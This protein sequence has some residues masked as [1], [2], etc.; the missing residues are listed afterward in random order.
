MMS[1]LPPESGEGGVLFDQLVG[2]HK[3]RQWHGE[4]ERGFDATRLGIID[5]GDVN[6][7]ARV[8]KLRDARL[9][10]GAVLAYFSKDREL[11]RGEEIQEGEAWCPGPQEEGDE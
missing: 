10:C 3:K 1:T 5:D 8:A 6:R 4:A 9:R 7:A 2:A 11:E